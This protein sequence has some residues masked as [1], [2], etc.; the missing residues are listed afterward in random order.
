MSGF[1]DKRKGQGLSGDRQVLRLRGEIFA[2][3]VYRV[4]TKPCMPTHVIAFDRDAPVRL[5]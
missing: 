1:R 5:I 3:D 4:R 2:V